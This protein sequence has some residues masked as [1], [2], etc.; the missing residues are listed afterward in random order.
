MDVSDITPRIAYTATGG[1]TAFVVPFVFFDQ[2]SLK[3]Y[4]NTVLLTLATHYTISGPA[5]FPSGTVTLLVGATAGDIIMIVRD[6]AI[7]QTTHIPPSGPLDIAAMNFQTSRLIAIDQQL[8]ERTNRTLH[9]PDSDA[10]L[11]G[12]LAAVAIRKNKLVGFDT[13]G[14]II[15]PLGPTFVGD[16]AT[17]VAVVDSRATAQVTTFAGSVN[18]VRTEGLAVPGD[19]GGGEYIRGLVGDPGAFQDG[20]G[21]YWKAATASVSTLNRTTLAAVDYNQRPVIFLAEAGR[22][23]WF[24]WVA[25]DQS[26][27]VTLDTL[28]GVYVQSSLVASTVGAWRRAAFEYGSVHVR[29]FGAKPDANYVG[30]GG[31]FGTLGIWYSDTGFTTGATDN[32]AAIQAAVNFV[33]LNLGTTVIQD[34]WEVH[35]DGGGYL[36]SGT[37]DTGTRRLQYRGVGTAGPYGTNICVQSGNQDWFTATYDS[38]SFYDLTFRGPSAGTGNAIVLGTGTLQANRCFSG[39]IMNCY[40]VGVG[41]ACVKLVN[42]EDFHINACTMEICQY[43][44]LG[45]MCDQLKVVNST[46]YGCTVA[47]ILGIQGSDW[48]VIGNNFYL[49]AHGVGASTPGKGG[50]VWDS[51]TAIIQSRDITVA[52]NTFDQCNIDVTLAGSIGAPAANTGANFFSILGNKSQFAD[53]QSIYVGGPSSVHI[54]NN[55]IVAANASG[56]ATTA[57]IEIVSSDNC[58]VNNNT[59]YHASAANKVDY[60]LRIGAGVLTCRIGNG[61]KF[62]GNSGATTITSMA[63]VEFERVPAFASGALHGG[64][65]VY[66]GEIAIDATSNRLCYWSGGLRYFLAGTSF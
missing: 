28:Q 41:G 7:E 42:A 38:V 17:G 8:N 13:A 1:Q 45:V 32:T 12:E 22:S 46:F 34:G 61:N 27:W 3:V 29:W 31:G 57:A 55:T 62:T 20:G 14:A 10:T 18:V 44:V 21:V 52:N 11:T 33:P 43:G 47:G 66:D 50:F 2:A 58:F 26:A 5:D 16:T 9:F 39:R 6:I 65:A 4:Q 54:A 19:G 56:Y 60:G 48:S 23:G 36:I 59:N 64:N 37:I 40:F 53:A 24:Q 30:R 51:T 63:S 35:F 15:Y 49:C 25:G